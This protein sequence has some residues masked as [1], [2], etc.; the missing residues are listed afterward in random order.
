[1]SVLLTV[2]FSSHLE[3]ALKAPHGEGPHLLQQPAWDHTRDHTRDHP[4]GPAASSSARPQPRSQRCSCPTA[5]PT[6][7]PRMSPGRLAPSPA[8][9]T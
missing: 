3:I 9:I 7:L 2:L 4:A 8:A 6:R 1:M 5:E